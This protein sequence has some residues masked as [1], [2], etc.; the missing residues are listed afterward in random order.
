MKKSWIFFAVIAFILIYTR[1]ISAETN[2]TGQIITGET[3]T[4]KALQ[5]SLALNITV[6]QPIPVLIIISPKNE[7]YLRNES[8]LINYSQANADTVWYNLDLGSNI[9]ITGPVY[10]N[11]S[12]GSHKIYLYGN[13]TYGLT[14]ET[15]DF[16]ANSTFFIILYSE[17]NGSTKGNSTDFISYTYEDLQNLDDIVL[18]NT[19]YGKVL[20]GEAINITNDKINTDNLLDLDSNTQIS[21]NRIELNSSELPNFNTSATLWIYNLSFTNPR[22]L[23][24][25]AVCPSTE[26]VK[27]IYEGE[28]GTLRF[29]VTHF[30]TYSAE[31]TPSAH[32]P[33]GGGG[34][35]K[36]API[37]IIK[38]IKDN[39]TLITKEITVSLE[40]GE[41]ILQDFNLVNNYKEV[42]IAKIEIFGIEKF[43]SLSETEIALPYEEIKTIKLNFSAPEGTPPDTYIG[44]II[45]KAAGKTYE[46]FVFINIQSEG[47]LFDVK[48]SIDK[49]KLP[50]TPGSY[51]FYNTI[52]YNLGKYKEIDVNMKYTIKD[53][54]EKIIFEGEGIEKIENYLEKEG[55]IKLPKNIS[56]GKY[57]LSV[58]VDYEGKSAVTSADF[59][60]QKRK[61]P[62]IW[63]ILIPIII[64]I[65]ILLILWKIGRKEEKK[66]KKDQEKRKD[67]LKY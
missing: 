9:T 48:L 40:Q 51:I 8:I 17:Y 23:K 64:L 31:E 41:T 54:Y 66:R 15:I 52:I 4:G 60:V 11:I 47:S 44:K 13:N 28:T 34:G 24:D 20:F 33:G 59:D 58:K 32:P 29:H 25:G 67:K 1:F 5:S 12:Q 30:T 27:E 45:I 26:C 37:E 16:I 50:A 39:I 6:T 43:L 65:I 3:V 56:N 22:I 35:E 36:E 14:S 10:I 62:L 2:I 46:S 21:L 38:E 55:K 63:K 49:E 42:I 19:L 53:S 18:E 57:V 61:L 7:T